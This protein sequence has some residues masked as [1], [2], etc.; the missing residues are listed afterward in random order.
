MPRGD[1]SE[2]TLGDYL[3]RHTKPTGLWHNLPVI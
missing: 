1:G 3:A 2:A